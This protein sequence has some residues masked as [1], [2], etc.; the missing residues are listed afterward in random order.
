LSGPHLLRAY[1]AAQL[2]LVAGDER[3]TVLG[4]TTGRFAG[5]S[6][7]VH[8]PTARSCLAGLLREVET[9]VVTDEPHPDPATLSIIDDMLAEF[10]DTGAAALTRWVPAT[11]ALKLERD[12][13]IRVGVDR[14]TVVAVRCPEVI[15]RD[16]L[17]RALDT[18]G[19]G[20]WINPTAEVARIGGRVRLFDRGMI[21]RPHFPD[22]P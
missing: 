5:P 16:A 1:T 19:A 13:I 18:A 12:G 10:P 2:G 14:S 9:V 15:D 22:K 6:V 21:V 11:E 20:V 17:T 8:L 3:V 4:A 7:L